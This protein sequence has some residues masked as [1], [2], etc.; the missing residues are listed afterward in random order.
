MKLNSNTVSVQSNLGCGT[1]GLLYLTVSPNVYAT[2]YGTAFVVPV[3]SGAATVIPNGSTG[4]QIADFQYTFQAATALFNEYDRTN[5]AL[6]QLLLSAV[7]E[8]YVRSLCHRYA[9]YGQTTT[10]Q[11]LDHLA[12]LPAKQ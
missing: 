5:K 12:S 8:I 1:L 9:G 2:L 6:R 11:L 4:P 3:K 7:E 10:R